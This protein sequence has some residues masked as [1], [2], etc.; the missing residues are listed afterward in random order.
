M[1]KE[2]VKRVLE[3]TNE[4]D[5]LKTI[6]LYINQQDNYTVLRSVDIR[7]ES[8]EVELPHKYIYQLNKIFNNEIEKLEEELECL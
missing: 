2:T 6:T 7:G 1:K 4:I 8:H 5:K 3:I